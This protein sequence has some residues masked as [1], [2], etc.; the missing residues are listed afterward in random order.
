VAGIN[1]IG[2]YSGIDQSTIDQLME[3]E[4][5][6]LTALA[7]KKTDIADKQN[8]WKD[9]KTRLNSLFE[10]L[11]VLK[12]ADTYTTKTTTSTD[13]NTVSMSANNG[14]AS[15]TYRINVSRLASST[16]I[17]GGKVET[18][19]IDDALSV[20]GKFSLKN[21]DGDHVEIEVL[22]TDSLKSIV[23]KVN[24]E[25]DNTGI[26]ATIIDNRIVL[27]DSKT[28]AR[29]ITLEDVDGEN[30]VLSNLKLIDAVDDADD[31][32]TTIGTT[33][34]FTI[35]GI[36]VEKDSNTLTDV[37]ENITINLKNTHAEGE[38]ETLT[39]SLD[40]SKVEQAVKAFVDQYNSTMTFIED[41]SAA[42]TPEDA[43]SRGVLA[44]DSTLQRL[45]SSLRS[46]VTSTISNSDNTSITDI[47]RLG[48]ST[49]DRYG[50]L[51]FDVSKLKEELNNDPQNVQNFFSSSDSLGNDVGFSYKLGDYVDSII[52]STNGVIKGKND[53]FERSL[54]DLNSQIESFNER[55][56]RKSAY[57][58]KIF[59]AL[60]VAMMEAESQMEWLTGQISAMTAQS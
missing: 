12:N 45:Q 28:G 39:V 16:S 30:S 35:N 9:I 54:K 34:K 36:E 21:N 3:I 53:S 56:E 37:V 2:S 47:S 20:S 22:T 13:E 7:T 14:A 32:T 31:P 5:L 29:T 52:S 49:V 46:L 10:K 8:A 41:K 59:S 19:S 50:Q 25:S 58:T 43:T 23:E 38:M 6:P 15:G 33:A 55:I 24:D 4:K 27:S 11:K 17:V 1:I 42:G 44:S 40:T 57:Y 60:D 26:S 18:S 48:I 51:T